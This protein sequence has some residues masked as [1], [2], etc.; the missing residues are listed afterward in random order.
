MKKVINGK[1][2]DTATAKECGDDH[3]HGGD[4]DYYIDTLYRKKTGEFFIHGEGGPRTKYGQHTGNNHWSGGE[5]IIPL[6]YAEARGW[7]EEHLTGDEYEAI[8]GPVA[9]DESRVQVCYSLSVAAAETIKRRAAEAGIS[10]SAY[11]E[12]LL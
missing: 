6:S 2:Y 9:E 1:L 5:K 4:L 7:A 11:I 8:F 3:H 12:S 10:V